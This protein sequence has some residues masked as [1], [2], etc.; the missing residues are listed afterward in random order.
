MS[1]RE[2]QQY[3]DTYTSVVVRQYLQFHKFVFI[4]IE[5]HACIYIVYICRQYITCFG[6]T[7]YICNS[8]FSPN[9]WMANSIWDKYC[10]RVK[11]YTLFGIE[12]RERAHGL[13]LAHR[14]KSKKTSASKK[15]TC[16]S[17]SSSSSFRWYVFFISHI[18]VNILCYCRKLWSRGHEC[19][20]I[21]SKGARPSF[22]RLN[23]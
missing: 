18:C 20:R 2:A 5:C 9:K 8:F 17:S 16:I 1:N 11:A 23:S 14:I 7:C 12:S 19:W 21:Q 13:L 4:S 6:I 22:S 3:D 10:V 15:I